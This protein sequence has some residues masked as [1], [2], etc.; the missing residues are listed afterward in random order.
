M[1][2]YVIR[3]GETNANRDGLLQGR[4]DMPLNESGLA[5]AAVTGRGL[6]GVRFDACISSPLIRTMQTAE[7]V[8]RES[9]NPDVSIETEPRIM[10]I[11]MGSWEGKKFRPGESE[12][13]DPELWKKHFTDPFHFTGAPNGESIP[14]VC[15]RT[16]A[17]LRDLFQR[18]DGK[19][20]LVSTHGCALRAML[21][22]LYDDPSDYW[23]GHVPYNCAV[24]I[25]EAN[26]GKGKLIE[27][28]RIYY[29]PRECIDRYAKF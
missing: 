9:G 11:N 10:E 5:L 26:G 29:D 24:S 19:T 27:K 6:R 12:I 1:I 2:I 17:F 13:E 21:N 23:Q 8:L 4:S 15:E 25:L 7:A 3:H 20:Y 16:Q 18:D 14:E 22:A 28:D